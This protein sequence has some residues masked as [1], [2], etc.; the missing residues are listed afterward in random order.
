MKRLVAWLT[1]GLVLAGLL[2]GLVLPPVVHAAELR[3]LADDK[4]A[5]RGGKVDLNNCSVVV[6]VNLDGAS[7]LLAADLEIEG[8]RVMMGF[9]PDL[10]CDV[11]KVPHQGAMDAALQEFIE[12]TD[13]QLGVV[14]VGKDNSYGH[15]SKQHVEMLENRGIKVLRTDIMGDIEITVDRG[16]IG[17][18]TER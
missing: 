16:R 4:I 11:L 15:P 13:P 1:S 2:M 12:S 14:S 8:Q 9:H 17:V 18:A 5:E 6:M 7:V 3:N 10:S